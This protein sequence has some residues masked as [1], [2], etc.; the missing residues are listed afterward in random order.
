MICFGGRAHGTHADRRIHAS[1]GTRIIG[2]I[3]ELVKV[4]SARE[5]SGF[6]TRTD[7]EERTRWRTRWLRASADDARTDARCGRRCQRTAKGISASDRRRKAT[8]RTL[9]R[10][11]ASVRFSWGRSSPPASRDSVPLSL[12][13]ASR[14]VRSSC[15]SSRPDRRSGKST[16]RSQRLRSVPTSLAVARTLTLLRCTGSSTFIFWKKRSIEDLLE[17][18]LPLRHDLLQI[19]SSE[20]PSCPPKTRS[21]PVQR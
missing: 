11:S 20:H 6:E 15:R 13:K 21:L 4:R 5:I 18:L 1:W 9:T 8:Q 10:P 16:A 17:L 14:R 7:D 2:D 19:S 12:V 3:G